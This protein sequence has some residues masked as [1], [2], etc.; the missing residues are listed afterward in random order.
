MTSRRIH[1]CFRHYWTRHRKPLPLPKS[2]PIND[3]ARHIANA[4]AVSFIAFKINGGSGDGRKERRAKTQA[5]SEMYHYFMYKR[6]E[7]L[8]HY[9]KRSNM[10]S[11][12]DEAEIRGFIA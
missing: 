12:Y 9:H 8:Q 1:R 10:E 11:T 7:F 5:W 4:G 3:N 2:Q 6:S